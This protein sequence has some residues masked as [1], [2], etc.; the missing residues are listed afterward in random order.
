MVG[1]HTAWELDRIG[2]RYRDIEQEKAAPRTLHSLAPARLVDLFGLRKRYAALAPV[3][4]AEYGSAS[5]IDASRQVQ[6]ELRVSTTGLLLRE[7][8]PK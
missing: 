8:K 3:L 1:L 2:G 5:F 6:L 7:A 4:D